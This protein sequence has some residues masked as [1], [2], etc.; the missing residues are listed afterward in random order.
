MR[1]ATRD[2]LDFWTHKS[3]DH[4]HYNG[5]TPMVYEVLGEDIDYSIIQTE[6]IPGLDGS[7]YWVLTRGHPSRRPLHD[8]IDSPHNV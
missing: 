1:P 3:Y 5:Q 2:D 4:Y 8:E 6:G 7:E